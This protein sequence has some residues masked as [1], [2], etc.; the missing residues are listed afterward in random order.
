MEDRRVVLHPLRH[1]VKQQLQEVG[2]PDSLI[3][4]LLRHAG[5]GETHGTCGGAVTVERMSEWIGRLPLQSILG[6][7][8]SS[9]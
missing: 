6:R 8:D 9:S 4:N 2:A 1:T 5:Q 3:A 7:D